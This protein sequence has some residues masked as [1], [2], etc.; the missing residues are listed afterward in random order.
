MNEVIIVIED[1]KSI[2][3]EGKPPRETFSGYLD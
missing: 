3:I 2:D 1:G